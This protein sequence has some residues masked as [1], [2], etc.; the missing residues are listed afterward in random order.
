MSNDLPPEIPR[1]MLLHLRPG[2]WY[3]D[4]EPATEPTTVR[5][6]AIDRSTPRLRSDDYEFWVSAHNPACTAVERLEHLPCASG[7]VQRAA[8]ER[9][10]KRSR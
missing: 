1:G 7:Y 8:I 6:V 2:E 9:N 10:W 4:Q 5:V 3:V